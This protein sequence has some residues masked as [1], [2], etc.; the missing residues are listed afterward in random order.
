MKKLVET[1]NLGNALSAEQ[2]AYFKNSKVRQDGKLMVCYH[3]TNNPG[4]KEFDP[5]NN[6]SQFG[7]Y[8]FGSANVNYFS[9]DLDSAASYTSIGVERDGNVYYVY[10]NIENPYIVDNQTI[11]EIRSSFNIQDRNIFEYR[12]SKFDDLLEKWQ[13]RVEYYEVWKDDMDDDERAEEVEDIL[14]EINKGLSL[15]DARI[16]HDDGDPDYFVVE[17]CGNNGVFGSAYTI[18][19]G[20]LFDIFFDDWCIDEMREYLL[21]DLDDPN[22][23]GYLSTDAVV[24]YVLYMNAN[25]GTDYDGIIIDDIIDSKSAFCESA[26]DVITLKSSNQIK[27]INNTHPTSN[28]RI[29]SATK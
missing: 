14:F 24:K 3:G 29:D 7:K 26:T 1:D 22:N 17:T 5:K 15:Y 27:Y 11:S 12:V 19:S 18:T 28:T 20:E 25:E 2:S 9:T 10:V 8:K 13:A 16:D 4:F 21:G 23:M 6:K